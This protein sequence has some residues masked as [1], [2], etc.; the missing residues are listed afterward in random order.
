MKVRPYLL[1]AVSLISS[2]A[3][4]EIAARVFLTP[5]PF[6]QD[7]DLGWRIASDVSHT[8][9][10]R[11]K[12]GATYQVPYV[13]DGA[14]MRHYRTGPGAAV[15]V[16]VAGDSMSMQANVGDDDTWYAAFASALA[17]RLG[18]PVEVTAAG[19]AGYGTLQELMVARQAV[20]TGQRFDMLILQS[21]VNDFQDNH[22]A[23]ETS[24]VN[25]ERYLIR[26]YLSEADLTSVVYADGWLAELYRSP[27]ARLRLF[28]RVD[29]A[30]QAVVYRQAASGF[31]DTDSRE[32]RLAVMMP[33]RPE[34]HDGA[35]AITTTLTKQIRD[36]VPQAQAF[37]LTCWP[38]VAGRLN[39]Q[40]PTIATASGFVFLDG[41]P[42][43][44]E[45]ADAAGRDVYNADGIHW[46]VE[47]SRIAGM[48]AFTAALPYLDLDGLAAAARP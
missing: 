28:G 26:P 16:L 29:R 11:T 32:A 4:L 42:Q 47:G 38:T 31:A 33:D 8:F 48:T 6:T 5:V 43:A 19:A 3:L 37:M 41:V 13:T 34:F 20:A 14:G 9:T 25:R 36:T 44:V 12:G 27:L 10:E 24:T 1:S 15:S 45:A 35:L 17:D 7:R 39:E 2:I 18:V 21:C 30:V 40:W 46:S 23:W 22:Q